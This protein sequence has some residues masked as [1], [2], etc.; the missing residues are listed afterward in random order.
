MRLGESDPIDA[1]AAAATALAGIDR[2]DH[3]VPKLLDGGVDTVRYLHAD[4]RSAVK[5]RT[6]AH[7]QI[8]S[9][10]VTT[11]ES[12]RSRYQTMGDADLIES[13]ARL[14][15]R[16]HARHIDAHDAVRAE[17]PGASSPTADPR[18]RDAR[19]RA[20]R[21]M[22][23]V[24]PALFRI[25]GSGSSRPPLRSTPP[26]SPTSNEGSYSTTAASSSTTNGYASG[27]DAIGASVVAEI[28][29]PHAVLWNQAKRVRPTN[30]S[31]A[32]PYRRR[33]T[34]T[35]ITSPCTAPTLAGRPN[36]I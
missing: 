1:Y 14:R 6:A 5:A 17:V 26:R 16:N 31:G 15:P 36:S 29:A 25:K 22:E 18:D 8:K 28:S 35:G 34:S 32:M 7:V 2:G 27:F 23:Q 13:L 12:T 3:L 19:S 9:L 24:A 33:R 11:P 10:L 21:G 4:R 20:G 30:G